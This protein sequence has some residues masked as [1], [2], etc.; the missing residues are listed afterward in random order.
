MADE[1][2]DLVD[3]D[4]GRVIGRA[5][6]ELCHGDP[7]LIHRAVHAAVF[8]PDGRILLQK[9]ARTKRVQPG[10]WD[11]SVGGHLISGED[12]SDALLRETEEE[13][14]MKVPFSAFRFRFETQERNDFESENIRVY[15]LVSPGPFRFQREE[16]DEVCFFDLRELAD[17]IVR[18]DA[19][20]LTPL[21]RREIPLLLAGDAE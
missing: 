15:S 14:G 12:W 21:L 4:T 19:E 6:R 5:P 1:W 2:F 8:H 10:R 16:I 20:D 13:L 11:I 3:P 7:S 18:H 9:R 17:R